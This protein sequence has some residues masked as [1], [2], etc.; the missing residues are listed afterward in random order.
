MKDKEALIWGQY[1][2]GNLLKE[3]ESYKIYQGNS[4]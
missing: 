2:I 3:D 4:L 1:K